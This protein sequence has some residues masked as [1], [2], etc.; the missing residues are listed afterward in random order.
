[1]KYRRLYESRAPPTDK[2]A[3]ARLKLCMCQLWDQK[4]GTGCIQL[5]RPGLVALGMLGSR[6][7][8]RDSQLWRRVFPPEAGARAPQLEALLPRRQIQCLA[9]PL[10]R[11]AFSEDYPGW[12]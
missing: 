8:K 2:G 11:L 3:A 4:I 10:F 7:A 5:D 1:M 6:L 12:I 9:A